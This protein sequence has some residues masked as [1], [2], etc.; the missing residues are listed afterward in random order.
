MNKYAITL[1]GYIFQV[2]EADFLAEYGRFNSVN[3]QGGVSLP[4]AKDLENKKP[5]LMAD[6]VRKAAELGLMS[7]GTPEEYGG[8]GVST[9]DCA[10]EIFSSPASSAS[11]EASQRS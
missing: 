5:G 1:R 3:L 6:L 8:A 4:L 9:M 10:V 7:G 2:I 11:S